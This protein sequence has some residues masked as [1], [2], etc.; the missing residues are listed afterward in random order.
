VRPDED[1]AAIDEY[2]KSMTPVPSPY[3]VAGRLSAKAKRGEKVYKAA[4][5]VTCHPP[6]LFTNMKP[7]N[8]GLG[9]DLDK[10]RDFDTPHHHRELADG[11]L[12]LRR[13]CRH[14]DGSVHP[15]TTRRMRT[16]RPRT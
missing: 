4:G 13:P 16:A 2:L 10:D 1:A 5:C 14:D 7:Y 6:S 8:M 12:P 3:L 9:R 11:A 15:S